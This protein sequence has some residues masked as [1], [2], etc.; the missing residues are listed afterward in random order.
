MLEVIAKMGLQDFYCGDVAAAIAA[1]LESGGSP[2]RR[3]GLAGE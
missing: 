1:D 2:I 3:A